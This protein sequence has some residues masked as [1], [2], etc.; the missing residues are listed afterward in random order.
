[1][2][3]NVETP[4]HGD[5]LMRCRHVSADGR[6]VSVFRTA[7]HTGYIQDNILR[8]PKSQLDGANNLDE[9]IEYIYIYIINLFVY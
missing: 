8:I 9:V 3:F 6:R 1:V 4:L 2:L 5:I 7:F